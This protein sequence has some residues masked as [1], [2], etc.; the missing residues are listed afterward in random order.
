MALQGWV[1]GR[2]LRTLCQHKLYC[3]F[4]SL[5]LLGC[6]SGRWLISQQERLKTV[7]RLMLVSACHSDDQQNRAGHLTDIHCLSQSWSLVHRIQS[8]LQQIKPLYFMPYGWRIGP[9]LLLTRDRWVSF[10][11]HEHNPQQ[12][13]KTTQTHSLKCGY[14]LPG[15]EQIVWKHEGLVW[16]VLT[17]SSQTHRHIFLALCLEKS[18]SSQSWGQYFCIN[19]NRRFRTGL[20]LAKP[21]SYTGISG[22]FF[23]HQFSK[24]EDRLA[25]S[26]GVLT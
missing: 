23:S 17:L 6:G 4:P 24:I 7:Q 9:I 14:E 21:L 19:I 10:R 12:A 5:L 13:T 25:L 8:T 3:F 22:T 1:G 26:S 15:N 2:L 18:Y 16:N 11:K 20:L